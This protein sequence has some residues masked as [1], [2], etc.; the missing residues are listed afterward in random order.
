MTVVIGA[1]CSDGLVLVTDAKLTNIFG[2]K[3]R[4]GRKLFGDLAH[5]LI[6]YTGSEE[7]FDI[8]RKYVVGDVVINRDT[9]NRYTPD[10]SIEKMALLVKKINLRMGNIRIGDDFE[11]LVA[12]HRKENSKLYYISKHGKS[13]EIKFKTIGSGAK[14]AVDFCR[15]IFLKKASIKEFTKSAYCSI[16]HLDR[17]QS[18]GVG[19]ITDGIPMMRY[20][21]YTRV[22]DK[23]P[24]ATHIEEFKRIA[25]EEIDMDNN[26]LKSLI[27]RVHVS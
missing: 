11:I 3:P 6:G 4:Y 20:L 17:I 12:Q 26:N 8:F 9:N 25:Q 16:I 2:G 24:P 21:R 27:K 15:P 1:T 13:K 23:P 19:V 22:W 5:L 14:T 7:V 10:N 18:S